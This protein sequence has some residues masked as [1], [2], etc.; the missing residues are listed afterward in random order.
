[1]GKILHILTDE[2]FSDYVI[3]QFE[4]PEMQSEFVLIPSNFDVD[5]NVKNIKKTQVV[6][7][8]SA[9]FRKLLTHL[10]DYSGIV[11]HGMHWGNWQAPILKAIPDYVKVAWVFWEAKY[12][13]VR[14]ALMI[15]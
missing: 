7:Q 6:R 2:K 1:M 5:S 12:M 8:G 15:F 14:I 3:N 9:E 11:F 10:G 13:D 4:T